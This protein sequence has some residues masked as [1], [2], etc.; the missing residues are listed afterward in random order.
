MNEIR[1]HFYNL[2]FDIRK[3]KKARFLDQKVT[4]DVLCIIAECIY[5]F[6][7]ENPDREFSIKDIWE[8]EYSKGVIRD[9]FGKPDT[10]NPAATR[11]F[12][13]FF[14]QPIKALDY[15]KILI[16]KRIGRGYIFKINNLNLLHFISIK[17][18]NAYV[19]LVL[20]IEKVLSDSSLLP[21]FQNFFN[22]QT[23]ESFISL[24]K[25]Y[26]D[27]IIKNTP[28]NGAVEVSRIFT[29]VLNPL[30]YNGRSRGTKRGFLSPD[31]INWH[32]LFYNRLNFRDDEYSKSRSETRS[33]FE[34]RKRKEEKIILD[35]NVFNVVRAKKKIK[36]YHRGV[37][38][39]NDEYAYRGVSEVN[40]E[41]TTGEATQVH[42]IFMR[43]DFPE[44]ESIL[45][46][47]ILL[48]PTQHL[49][50]AHP[51]NNTRY[52]DPEYQK[53]CLISKNKSIKESIE[54]EDG[55]Y[56]KEDFIFVVNNG[57]S[58]DLLEESNSFEDIERKIG[59]R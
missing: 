28:I 8:N 35:R 56:S 34:E 59:E 21:M 38:E 49:A 4:P 16:S 14:A 5:E 39:V 15:S 54:K 27:F 20:Y 51:H 57:Y 44:M 13:K 46:N 6:C 58:L 1:Q 2:D 25:D 24:K 10:D 48:T 52:I 55:F 18:R 30:A 23:K 12:D 7:K 29:K 53:K 45:E 19:F 36:E 11:E 33:D 3:T 42:H 17:E 9:Y 22:T 31:I 40:D 47:L 37:S 50:K 32:E 26:T 41:Y 43:S